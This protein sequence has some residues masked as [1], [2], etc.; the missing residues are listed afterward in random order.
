[1]VGLV[2]ILAIPSITKI[3]QCTSKPAS[4]AKAYKRIIRTIM[5]ITS[6]YE[7]SPD[8]K[9]SKLW[10]SLKAVRN[11]HGRS[12]RFCQKIGAGRIT[13]KDMAITQFGFMGFLTLGLERIQQDDIEFFE[14]FTHMWRVFGYLLGMKDEYNIC[15]ENWSESKLRLEI[16][17]RQVIQPALEK[18]YEEFDHLC[19]LLF[20]GVWTIDIGIHFSI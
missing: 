5:H 10:L 1:M 17:M 6:W 20:E 12:S 15:G 13:Q 9:N 19:N 11:A 14:C 3:I 4:S 16:V 18:P 7:N 2:G 8:D